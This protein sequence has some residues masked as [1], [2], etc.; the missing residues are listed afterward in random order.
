MSKQKIYWF[1]KDL[2][3]HDQ[4]V[5]NQLFREAKPFVAFYCLD[6]RM[7]QN[8]AWGFQGIAAIRL[9]FLLDHLRL[10]ES[11]LAELG[12]TLH[13]Q[14]GRPAEVL[15]AYMA[16]NQLQ[17]VYAESLAGTREQAEEVLLKNAAGNGSISL[18]FHQKHSLLA[19]DQ[20]PF[21]LD[22]LPHIFTDFRKSVEKCCVPQ[23]VTNMVFPKWSGINKP[24]AI[25][26]LAD[27]GFSTAKRDRRID[28]FF[29]AGET[30]GKAR[31]QDYFWENE[32]IKQY[33]L[34]RNGLLGAN[35][36]SRFSAWLALGALSPRY[37]Y[38]ELK[39][40]ENENG[41]NES[42]YWLYFELLWRDY[43]QFVARKAGS[44]LFKAGGIQQTSKAKNFDTVVFKRWGLG[45]TGQPFI[46]ANMR[47]LLHTGWMSNR[48]R[49]NVASYLIHDLKQDWRA[50]AAWFEAHL[51]DYD[52][53]S[54]YGNWNY[55]AGVGNDPRENRRFNPEKQAAQYDPQ[56]EYQRLWL[57]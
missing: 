32:H 53:A 18:Y 8:Y 37:I 27:L 10:L 41:A 49:Q 34:T 6:E 16:E 29:E 12:V 11:Q 35:Y 24:T 17:E 36:S 7:F 3:L 55:L 20:L 51:I 45:E 4:P 22:Q 26:T 50:G 2:R 19:L 33:K 28:F 1:R 46:D 52:V 39:R 15:L 31:V 57:S 40:F 38:S 56:G 25:P 9:Q 23:A 21:T 54:N 30:A 44:N 42:T 14:R 5:L 13:I 48:G 47:E 43:F